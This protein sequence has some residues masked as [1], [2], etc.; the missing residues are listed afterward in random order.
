MKVGCLTYVDSF[1]L[2]LLPSTQEQI[3]DQTIEPD[4]HL[5]AQYDQEGVTFHQFSESESVRLSPS[6]TSRASI[7]TAALRQ[8]A[9]CDVDLYFLFDAN[10]VYSPHYIESICEYLET[11]E[12]SAN[13]SP[14]CLNLTHQQIL[15]RSSAAAG[16]IVS[17]FHFVGGLDLSFEEKLKG[18]RLGC[19]GT[20]VMNRAAVDILLQEAPLHSQFNSDSVSAV[21]RQ[22]LLKHGVNITLVATPEPVCVFLG[23]LPEELA[24]EL[25]ETRSI[26][27][28]RAESTQPV[29]VSIIV[30]TYNEGDWLYRTIQSI[31]ENS[32][33]VSHE[34]IV[35]DDGCNDGS[36]ERL[37]AF[38]KVR[39]VRSANPQSGVIAAKNL[40]AANAQGD[41]FCFVDSHMIL[42]CGW[43]DSFYAASQ[44]L[45]ADA[46][47]TCNIKDFDRME[48]LGLLENAQYGYT[49]ANWKLGVSWHYYGQKKYSEPYKTPL[50]PG[51]MT[52]VSRT[53]FNRVRGFSSPM[54]KW[55]SEDVDFSL[56]NYCAG[57]QTYCVPDFF[58]FH[59]FKNTTTKKPTFSITYKQ[60]A[61]NTLYLARTFFSVLDYQNVKRALRKTGNIDDIILE[62][63]A[64]GFDDEI[65]QTRRAFVRGIESWREEFRE[66]LKGLQN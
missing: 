44:K 22:A 49:L 36:I 53:A 39:I 61:F 59:Y 13:D 45:G 38:S 9:D 54:R 57:G 26:R 43:L 55:G 48:Q 66:E 2:R 63:E 14:F 24:R 30:P 12:F 11:S 27:S 58:V 23:L 16:R 60:T 35:V 8:M 5:V 37:A 56:K 51:G 47:L 18:Q 52:F 41:Y 62:I 17:D 10:V 7:Q 64:G 40:G 6:P 3:A 15:S 50:C 46:L 1:T 29:S 33:D 19:P 28:V 32:I 4:L 20:F 31:S 25:D 42:P 34:I 65:R 21:W